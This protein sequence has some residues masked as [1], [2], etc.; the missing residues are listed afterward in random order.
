MSCILVPESNISGHYFN[1]N[2]RVLRVYAMSSSQQNKRK[3]ESTEIYKFKI[4]TEIDLIEKNGL[5]PI[6]FDAIRENY[7]IYIRH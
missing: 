2:V 6:I 7:Q 3:P 1:L 4:K 5:W